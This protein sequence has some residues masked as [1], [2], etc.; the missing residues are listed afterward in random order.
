MIGMYFRNLLLTAIAAFAGA[1]A[2]LLP[3]TCDTCALIVAELNVCTN[4]FDIDG[5]CDP[6]LACP[7][8][9]K[10]KA[11]GGLTIELEL[12]IDRALSACACVEL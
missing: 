7:C 1:N 2:G 11:D 12:A 8:W 6:K 3:N 5:H 10:C 9:K 4:I